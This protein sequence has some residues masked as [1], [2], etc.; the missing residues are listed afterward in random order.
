MTEEETIKEFNEYLSKYV[1][2]DKINHAYMIETNNKNTL[3]MA[4][5][6]VNKIIE[7][8]N[9]TIDE[10]IRN[11]DLLILQTESNLIKTEDVENLKEQLDTKSIYGNKRIYIIDGAEKLSDY[12]ANKLLKFIEEPDS[13]IIAILVTSNKNKV[14]NTIVSRCQI[15]RFFKETNKFVNYDKEYIDYLFDFIINIEDNKEAAICFQNRIDIKRLSD[16]K[17]LEVF[18]NNLLYAYDDVINYKI[19]N[20]VEYFSNVIDKI[21]YISNKNTINSIRKKINA[22]N[23]CIMRLKYNPNIKLLIDKLI[24]LMTGVDINA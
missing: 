18:L 1:K 4:K 5:C 2:S 10:M 9:T 21:E 24:I 22:I 14:I 11:N 8:D 17:E 20:K 13:G 12:S 19:S 15:L 23:E 7:N 16:R 3:L 6:L